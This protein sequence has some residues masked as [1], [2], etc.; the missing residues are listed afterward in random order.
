MIV[1][2][3][4]CFES[5]LPEDCVEDEDG[6]PLQPPGRS[7]ADAIIEIL[8]RLGYA[9]DY[10]PEPRNDFCWDLVVTSGG[11]RYS[12]VLNLADRYYLSLSHNSWL[13][14]LLGRDPPA[15]LDLLRS[16]ANALAVD[17]RFS[18]IEWF[19]R[20]RSNAPGAS[21]PFDETT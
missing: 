18:N 4:A 10:G 5:S 13:D 19:I 16:F 8:T 15:F 3:V 21:F 2:S 7:V 1:R 9:I 12:A 20:G 11:R 14:K 17:S 6:R